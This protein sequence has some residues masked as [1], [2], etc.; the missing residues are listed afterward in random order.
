MLWET[1]PNY[2]QETSQIL[3]NVNSFIAPFVISF[4]LAISIYQPWKSHLTS[5]MHHLGSFIRLVHSLQVGW[6]NSSVLSCCL[7]MLTSVENSHNS[8]KM[9]HPMS[10]PPRPSK[11]PYFLHCEKWR[12]TVIKAW[13]QCFLHHIWNTSWGSLYFNTALDTLSMLSFQSLLFLTETF[14]IP[15]Q[16]CNPEFKSY[17]Q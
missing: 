16:F 7:F 14:T 3:S 6:F 4:P 9:V 8:A 2:W 10:M 15:F 5:R 1:T 12:F 13:L 17:I 11:S